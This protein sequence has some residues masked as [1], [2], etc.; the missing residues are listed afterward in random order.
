MVDS[1]LFDV[2][3]ERVRRQ[4]SLYDEDKV[5]DWIKSRGTPGA[6]EH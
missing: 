2:E 3:V 6:K 4:R 5:G 1:S